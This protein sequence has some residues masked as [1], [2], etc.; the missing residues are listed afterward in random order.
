MA[1]V[2]RQVDFKGINAEV[3]AQKTERR[4]RKLQEKKE[5]KIAE[6]S[7]REDIRYFLYFL[8]TL[9][10]EDRHR[11]ITRDAATNGAVALMFP[12]AEENTRLEEFDQVVV[13][14]RLPTGRKQVRDLQLNDLGRFMDR[15]AVLGLYH[16]ELDRFLQFLRVSVGQRTLEGLLV[17][18]AD[19]TEDEANEARQMAAQLENDG[20]V[21]TIPA[22]R[23]SEGVKQNL[24]LLM[25][26][27]ETRAAYNY[28]QLAIRSCSSGESSDEGEMEEDI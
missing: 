15:W 8:E 7:R 24:R 9:T 4:V 28:D 16:R 21:G 2:S 18:L 17:S 10:S 1:S 5:R 20:R 19:G 27:M 26:A 13:N 12:N 25:H 6:Q 11:L 23:L 3:E 22:S 14:R